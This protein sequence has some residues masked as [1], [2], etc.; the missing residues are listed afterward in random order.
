LFLNAENICIYTRFWKVHLALT[1]PKY[2]L[3]PSNLKL[4]SFDFE[5]SLV[6]NGMV[7]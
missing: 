5:K 4:V 3:F 1:K 2:I 7:N 6:E